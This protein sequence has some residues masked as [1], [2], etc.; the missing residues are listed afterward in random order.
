MIES[1]PRIAFTVGEPAGIGPDIAIRL[2][3]N[4]SSYKLAVIADPDMMEKRAELLDLPLRIESW[5]E[6]TTEPGTM[7]VVTEPLV[8]TVE[9]GQLNSRNSRSVLRC[10]DRAVDGC[11]G[12]TFDAMTTGPV[13]KGVINQAG[14]RFFGHT[15][16][17]SERTGAGMPVMMLTTQKTRVALVTTHIPL[18]QVS[19]AITPE[20]LDRV[21]RVLIDDM[22][23]KFNIESPRIAVCGLNP[24]A[25]EQGHLG[26]EE[27]EIVS[28]IIEGFKRKGFQIFGPLPADTI[29][30]P[31]IQR[32]YD[33]ILTMYHD[34]GLPV[35]KHQG[36]DQAVNVTLGIPI[37]RTSVDHGT[38]LD[39]VGDTRIDTGSALAALD[40]AA[41]LVRI[42]SRSN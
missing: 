19:K 2:A 9:P 34:Q 22:R 1:A 42:K 17:I 41:D 33:V 18:N 38:A 28:P 12:G 36:F 24:H 31:E 23:A 7:A 21:I 11:L 10:I 25:G 32:Q 4:P 3:H 40:L 27:V 29:F 39:R 8:E 35:I 14:I 37:I 5:Q 26:T 16:Y 30:V 13:H 20:R 15:E 6:Q